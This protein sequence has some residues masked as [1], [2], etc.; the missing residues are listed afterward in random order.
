MPRHLPA[1]MPTVTVDRSLIA[2]W[3]SASVIGAAMWAA[4][5]FG[6]YSLMGW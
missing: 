1:D 5:G 4:I 3:T 2:W 6:V